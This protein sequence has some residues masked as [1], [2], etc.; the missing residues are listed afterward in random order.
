MSGKSA[1]LNAGAAEG[2]V[3]HP[4]G[5][6]S[7]AYG[8]LVELAAKHTVPEAPSLKP[9]EEWR[10]IGKERGRL[11]AEAKSTG[12]PIYGIDVELEGM[13]YAVVSRPASYGARVKS[14]D[15]TA[16]RRL[17]GVLDV[18]EIERGVAVVAN[19]YWR[20]R[21]AQDALTI[22]WDNDGALDVSSDQVFSSYHKAADEDPGESERSEGD[23]DD[24]Q[25]GAERVVE[26]SYEQPYLAQCDVGADERYGVVSGRRH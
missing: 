15:D 10:Y 1:P 17:P 22:E 18:F 23:Y 3:V 16:A 7:L 14:Y 26:A 6:D 8:R 20:A 21:K 5:R 13:V 11:D 24:A 4:N 2:R 25:Q 12:A 9:R 19:K